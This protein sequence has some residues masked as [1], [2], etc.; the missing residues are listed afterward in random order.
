MTQTDLLYRALK[1]YRKLTLSH[2]EST[3]RREAI[4][5]ANAEND[6]FSVTRVHCSVEEDWVEAIEEGLPFI[7]KAIGE[8]RQFILSQGETEQIEKVKHVSKESVAHLARHSN[9]I[10][11]AEE[12][13]DIVPDRLYTVERLNDYTVYE[14]RFLYLVLCNLRDFVTVRRDRILEL[15]NT[16]SGELKFDKVVNYNKERLVYRM[17]LSEERKDDKYLLEH[18]PAGALLERIELI[19]RA[20]YYYLRTPLMLEVAK[21]DKLKPPITK[22]NVLRMDKNFKEVV[23]LYEF[24]VA[25]RKDGYT[26]EREVQEFSP[27]REPI[28]DEFAETVM[29]ASFLAYEHGLGIEDY[30]LGEYEKEE[31]RRRL[32]EA[33]RQRE[34][35]RALKKRIAANGGA[36]EY[37]L[38]LEQRNKALEADS[39]ELKLR[40]AEV[41]KLNGE[42]ASL[43]QTIEGHRIEMEKLN[44]RHGAELAEL[45]ARIGA[46][47]KE[48]DAEREAHRLAMREAED[49]FYREMAARDEAA[50]TAMR[51]KEGELAECRKQLTGEE[52]RRRLAEGRL[53]AMRFE[54]GL[55]AEGD[56][57]SEEGFGELEHQYA[58]FQ[59]FF[60]GQWRKAR[61]RIRL[62]MWKATV[63]SILA[64]RKQKREK[65]A[66]SADTENGAESAVEKSEEGTSAETLENAVEKTE[67]GT[68][69]E[70]AE[71]Q[72]DVSR[73]GDGDDGN[74]E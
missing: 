50:R 55:P 25:Y 28:A 53:N 41:E 57:T 40:R 32:E 63:A 24:L 2:R 39:E 22:T 23:K 31:E 73:A 33:E 19:L 13:K 44:E 67:E 7:G 34:R 35:I 52:E 70:T 4:A 14:N 49:S 20:V 9:Y 48:K 37:M 26:V 8:E 60:R 42:I 66:A 12:G 59:A 15:A 27:L 43:H 6:R 65:A 29:L 54:Q 18:N 58:V 68:S 3:L 46:I 1:E 5:K 71:P 45:N 11:R 74:D 47:A 36:E 17:T 16:Y 64:Q 21:T 61:R 72:Q 10:T 56:L 38:L 62:E 51:G 30:L 69:A